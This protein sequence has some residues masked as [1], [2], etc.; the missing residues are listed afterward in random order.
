MHSSQL[1]G[2][3]TSKP[4][5]CNFV[6]PVAKQ[7]TS[8]AVVAKRDLMQMCFAFVG[9]AVKSSSAALAGSVALVTHCQPFQL[10]AMT[11]LSS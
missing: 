9:F 10:S 5:Q 4:D 11:N 1:L 2:T 6:S 7:M 3:S 8:N